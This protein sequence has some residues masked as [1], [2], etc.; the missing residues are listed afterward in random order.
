MDLWN[1]IVWITG[2]GRGIGAATA[3]LLAEHGARIV[4]SS[5]SEE[6]A[7]M[8]ASRINAEGGSALAFRCDVR[9][10]R[11]IQELVEQTSEEWGPIDVLVN[12]AGV[13]H[14]KKIIETSPEEW[15]EMM[16][17]NLKAAFLCTRAVLPSMMDRGEGHIVNIV[18]VAGMQPY[19]KSGGYCA[20]K[21]GLLGFTEVLRLETRKYGIKVTAVAPGATLTDIWGDRAVDPSRMMRPQDVA[22]AVLAVLLADPGAMVETVVLR[23]QGG[24]L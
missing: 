15:D 6:N 11:Q 16:D 22:R 2:S 12:N 17:V 14:F 19:Y 3:E 10:E 23:P 1:K 18:S 13:A 21:Y 4:V 24:D 20:S 5:R 8:V 9:D 7:E